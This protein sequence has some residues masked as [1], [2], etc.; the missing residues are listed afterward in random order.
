MAWT[1]VITAHQQANHKSLIYGPYTAFYILKQY[2]YA[3]NEITPK[4]VKSS[5]SLSS[6]LLPWFL[7]FIFLFLGYFLMLPNVAYLLHKP[8]NLHREYHQSRKQ[9][10]KQK[11]ECQ[12][13]DSQKF[14][15]RQLTSFNWNRKQKKQELI[16]NG[17]NSQNPP[18]LSSFHHAK[19]N[20]DFLS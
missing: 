3:L 12:I 9:A 13:V 20:T 1:L 6:I 5:C 15:P 4:I 7:F 19:S 8:L 10:D 14:Y 18:N 16:E 11:M 17:H 2:Q